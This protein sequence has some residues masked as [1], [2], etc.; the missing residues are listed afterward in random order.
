MKEKR[1]RRLKKRLQLHNR[2]DS[3]YM[4][5]RLEGMKERGNVS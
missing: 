1:T 5:G 3:K 2:K 4:K